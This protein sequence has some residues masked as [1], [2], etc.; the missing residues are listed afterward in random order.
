MREMKCGPKTKNPELDA[1]NRENQR[2]KTALCEASIELLLLKKA[3]DRARWKPEWVASFVLMASQSL[4]SIFDE[5]KAS[6]EALAA[7]C[8][9]TVSPLLGQD[10]RCQYN[11][12]IEDFFTF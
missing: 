9:P 8:S 3:G 2:L 6:G 1:A 10:R 4:L 12:Q 5:A 11:S 7:T